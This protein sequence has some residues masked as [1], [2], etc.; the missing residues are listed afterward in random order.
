MG[1]REINVQAS[2]GISLYPSDGEDVESLLKQADFKM[3]AVKKERKST[4]RFR[5]ASE[6]R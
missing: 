6:N 3:Y 2:I 4:K 1:A 5:T